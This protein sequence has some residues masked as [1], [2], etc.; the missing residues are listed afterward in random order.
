[1]LDNNDKPLDTVPEVWLR[2][3]KQVDKQN[4]QNKRQQKEHQQQQRKSLRTQFTRADTL[5]K[6]RKEVLQEASRLRSLNRHLAKSKNK[7][8]EP[9][10]LLLVVRSDNNYNKRKIHKQVLEVLK[11]LRL[12]KV[13]SAVFLRTST[14][15]IK[16]K[17]QQIRP[18]VFMGTPSLDS[19]R[20]LINKRAHTV[21]KSNSNK[22]KIVPVSDNAMVEEALG[23]VGVICVED[24]IHE[25]I[26]GDKDTFEKVTNYLAPFE[27]NTEARNSKK[28]M[29]NKLAEQAEGQRPRVHKTIDSFVD[30]YN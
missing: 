5:I 3:R 25:I 28:K 26:N 13:H 18:Y 16:L 6:Q 30:Y 14:P 15:D 10:K 29:M 4:I 1:M 12:T 27:L 24:I 19:V 23:D 7:D 21:V 20:N 11:E 22:E 9:E 17:L 8:D 2:K